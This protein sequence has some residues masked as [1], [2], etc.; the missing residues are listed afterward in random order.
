MIQHRIFPGHA[1]HSTGYWPLN[2]NFSKPR[3][4]QSLREGGLLCVEVAHGWMAGGVSCIAPRYTV[5]EGVSAHRVQGTLP[6]FL[7]G[8]IAGQLGCCLLTNAMANEMIALPM[9]LPMRLL[10]CPCLTAHPGNFV[11]N[12]LEQGSWGWTPQRGSSLSEF[13]ELRTAISTESFVRTE[14]RRDPLV[15]VQDFERVAPL[16]RPAA[17]CG[18]QSQGP[19]RLCSKGTRTFQGVVGATVTSRSVSAR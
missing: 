8:R 4:E 11:H 5:D 18:A 16:G 9:S 7:Q 3:G 17:R 13:Q 6:S 12:S 19:H 14:L 10:P 1:R 15:A 2:R